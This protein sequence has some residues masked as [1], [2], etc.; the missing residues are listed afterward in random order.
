MHVMSD[1]RSKINGAPAKPK[2]MIVV[3]LFSACLPIIAKAVGQTKFSSLEEAE[4]ACIGWQQSGDVHDSLSE[5][6]AMRTY[7]YEV[8]QGSCDYVTPSLTRRYSKQMQ[9]K[10]LVRSRYCINDK[11]TN[12]I[13]GKRNDAM[14]NGEWIERGNEDSY[15]LV[16]TFRY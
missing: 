4:A 9:G 14:E 3:L 5:E 2:V 7:G 8:G 16:K 6:D 13:E 10:E 12:T 1:L 15:E 11:S